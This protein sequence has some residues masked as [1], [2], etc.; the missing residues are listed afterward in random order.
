MI[1]IKGAGVK[2]IMKES[3]GFADQDRQFWREF[4]R[5]TIGE[6]CT[7]RFLEEPV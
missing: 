1:D 4:T 5:V 6:G 7:E 2:L 3:N